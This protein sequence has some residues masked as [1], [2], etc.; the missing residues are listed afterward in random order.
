M[1]RAAGQLEHRGGRRAA[2]GEPFGHLASIVKFVRNRGAIR[3]GDGL[4][5]LGVGVVDKVEAASI[6]DGE[7][8]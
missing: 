4:W 7:R 3:A 8:R 1:L 6:F 5:V 2:Q